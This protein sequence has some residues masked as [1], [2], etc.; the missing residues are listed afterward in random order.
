MN[1]QIENVMQ[2]RETAIVDHFTPGIDFCCGDY[3]QVQRG[4]YAG[5][6]GL[7]IGI[8]Y[9]PKRHRFGRCKNER[10]LYRVKLSDKR[11]VELSAGCMRFL[12]DNGRCE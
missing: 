2:T 7:I 10:L 12:N 1:K 11:S 3:V 4:E 9:I 6:T 5:K 8:K